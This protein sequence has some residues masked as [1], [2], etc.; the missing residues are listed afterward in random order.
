MPPFRNTKSYR[1]QKHKR[2]SSGK[3]N[4]IIFRSRKS[5]TQYS[6]RYS[7]SISNIVRKE[8]PENENPI[9]QNF[10]NAQ[11]SNLSYIVCRSLRNLPIVMRKVSNIEMDSYKDQKR[12][13]IFCVGINC[14]VKTKVMVL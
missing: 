13:F 9:Q 8:N 4:E 2:D 12:N 5:S 1:N 6:D 11:I 3:T 14:M 7:D 10:W